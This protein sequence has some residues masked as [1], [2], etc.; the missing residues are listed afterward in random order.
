[1]SRFI[2]AAAV[3]IATAGLVVTVSATPAAALPHPQPGQ[4][5]TY[6]YYSGPD[7]ITVVGA[8]SAP[9][10][11]GE[12]FDWGTHTPYFSIRYINCGIN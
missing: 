5:I 6:T 8:S 9:G 7:R 12:A 11:C 4:S 3:A 10:D 2:R 1:M